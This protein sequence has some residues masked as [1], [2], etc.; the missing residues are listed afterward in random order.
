MTAQKPVLDIEGVGEGE[1]ALE[2]SQM[3]PEATNQN[4]SK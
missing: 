4:Q 2:E 3:R 1:S